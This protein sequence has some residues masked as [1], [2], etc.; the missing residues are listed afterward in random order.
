MAEVPPLNRLAAERAGHDV[1]FLYIYTRETHPGENIPPHRSYEEKMERA[2]AFQ[3]EEG[4]ELT[5]LVDGFEGPVHLAYGG[6]PNMACVVHRDGR[7][8]YRSEWADPEALRDEIDHLRRWDRWAAAEGLFRES[9]VEMVRAWLEDEETHAVRKR[10]YKR[11]GEQAVKDFV[12]KT[13]RSP[14]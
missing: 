1:R 10:T 5:L 11:A 14:V 9:R 8:I 12:A 6:G 2:R 4:L 3:A 7:L 13:G